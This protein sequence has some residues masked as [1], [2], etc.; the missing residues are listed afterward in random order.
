MKLNTNP[1]EQISVNNNNGDTVVVDFWWRNLSPAK[2]AL[3]RQ[4]ARMMEEITEERRIEIRKEAGAIKGRFILI[5]NKP[6]AGALSAVVLPNQAESA[7]SSMSSQRH[8]FAPTRPCEGGT[9]AGRQKLKN[10]SQGCQRMAHR[11]V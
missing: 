2:K 11:L 6:E 3:A 5:L 8:H 10:I 1:N 9:P 4:I 7:S